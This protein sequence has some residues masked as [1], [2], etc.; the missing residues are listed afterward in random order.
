MKKSI[1]SLTKITQ[2][3]MLLSLC[4][5]L[6]CQKEGANKEAEENMKALSNRALEIWSE[7]NYALLDELYS[8]DIIR[9]EVNINEDLV[10][11][12][13]YKDNVIL[14][15]TAYPDFNVTTD[16]LFAKD[17]RVVLRWTVTGTNTGPIGDQ[18]ATGKRVHFSGVNINRF[19]DGKIVEEWVYFNMSAE[20]TQLGYK[21]TP[22]LP[23]KEK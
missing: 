9:H 16:E 22:P 7:G 6:S 5:T 14:V 15:R 20:L 21:I 19:I 3:I 23:E 10:G 13:E 17:D 4:F 11:P 2:I 1:S 18:L 12:K 8:P